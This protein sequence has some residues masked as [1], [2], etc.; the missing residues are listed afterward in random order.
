LEFLQY[1]LPNQKQ[2]HLENWSLDEATGQLELTVSSTQITAACPL[3]QTASRK[4]HS[5]Y[6][7]TLKDIACVEY[8]MKLLLQVRKFFCTNSACH[9][10][11]FTE[12]LPQLTLPWAGQTCRLT[13]Q[14]VVIGLALGGAAGVRLSQ[15]LG[16]R[17][18]RKTLLNLLVKQALPPSPLVKTLGVDDFAFRKGQRYGTILVDLD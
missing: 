17:M 5:R 14:L 8:P 2:L 4:V 16:Y 12:R 7:R 10:R 3:C 15:Q 9:R 13:K 11:I 6:E 18:S 1:L